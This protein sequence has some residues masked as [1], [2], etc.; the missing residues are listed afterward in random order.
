MP[1]W[2]KIKTI[3]ANGGCC[4]DLEMKTS[5]EIHTV[6]ER[7]FMKKIETKNLPKIEQKK[8]SSKMIYWPP[9]HSPSR[10]IFDTKFLLHVLRRKK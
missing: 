5:V 4:R 1:V 7:I 6:D 3:H 10:K 8:K 9:N 2:H